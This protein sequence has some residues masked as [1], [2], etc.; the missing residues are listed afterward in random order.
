MTEHNRRASDKADYARLTRVLEDNQD[1]LSRISS[2][3]GFKKEDIIGAAILHFSTLPP[4][5]QFEIFTEY[6]KLE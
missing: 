4:Q 3:T 1:I 6:L 2:H 5:K